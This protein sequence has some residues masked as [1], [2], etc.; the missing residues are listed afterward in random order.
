MGTIFFKR[1]RNVIQST[2][3][4]VLLKLPTIYFY[5]KISQKGIKG[6]NIT[7]Y[8]KGISN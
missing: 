6:L 7:K 5:N 1:K 3:N 2:S 8:N 4:T